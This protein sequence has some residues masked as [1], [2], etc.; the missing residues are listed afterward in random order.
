L[1]TRRAAKLITASRWRSMSS[2][3]TSMTA[4]ASSRCR[5]NLPAAASREQHWAISAIAASGCP[6]PAAFTEIAFVSILSRRL[7]RLATQEINA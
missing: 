1:D 4:R 5:I 7:V 3:Q 6:K 2:R